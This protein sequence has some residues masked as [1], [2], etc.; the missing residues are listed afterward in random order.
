MGNIDAKAIGIMAGV[1][2]GVCL[3]GILLSELVIKP[4]LQKAK[5]KKTEEPSKG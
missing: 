1:A 4:G 2:A 3:V 5:S